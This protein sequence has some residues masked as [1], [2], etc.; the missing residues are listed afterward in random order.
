MVSWT[1]ATATKWEMKDTRSSNPHAR[2]GMERENEQSPIHKMDIP[3]PWRRGGNIIYKHGRF[4]IMEYSTICLQAVDHWFCF[5]NWLNKYCFCYNEHL[6]YESLVGAF[7]SF[8]STLWYVYSQVMFRIIFAQSNY[9]CLVL[10][11]T[12]H[13]TAVDTFERCSQ[14]MAETTTHQIMSRLAFHYD[15]SSL[16]SPKFGP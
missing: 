2:G 12:W 3:V 5:L 15:E 13:K 1:T 9:Y 11:H 14:S 8:A 16:V 10:I 6:R 7:A 4:S